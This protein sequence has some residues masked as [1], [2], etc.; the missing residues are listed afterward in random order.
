LN[1]F[2]LFSVICYNLLHLSANLIWYVM[3]YLKFISLFGSLFL[4]ITNFLIS[5]LAKCLVVIFRF[6]DFLELNI[7]LCKILQ[8]QEHYV[9]ARCP[10]SSCAPSDLSLF[11]EILR[12]ESLNDYKP[13]CLNDFLVVADEVCSSSKVP[14]RQS[15]L[16]K[17][18]CLKYFVGL[19]LVIVL[20]IDYLVSFILELIWSSKSL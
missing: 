17:L 19:F 2:T 6:L 5:K 4:I 11:W 18:C 8:V 10:L 9:G 3:N 13:S 1:F 7:E 15:N 16:L 12:E 20:F 14:C